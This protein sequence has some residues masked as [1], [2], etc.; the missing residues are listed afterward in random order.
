MSA[1]KYENLSWTETK[2]SLEDRWLI[3]PIGAIE[4]HGPHLPLAVDALLA[5][6][7]SWD[8]AEQIDAVV[9]PTLTY[10]G[11]SLPNSGGGPSYPGTIHLQGNTLID[12]YYQIITRFVHLGAE[13]ILLLNAHWENEPFMI[14]AVEICREYGV[15]EQAQVLAL[16]WWSV[17]DATEME[18]IFGEFHGWHVEHAGQAETALMLHY[19]PELV[20]MDKAVDYHEVIPAGI[21]QHPTPRSWVGNQGV[22]SPTQHVVP[23]MGNQL[24]ILLKEKIS[25]LV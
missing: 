16:S 10:G 17:I 8:V 19:A 18:R 11:R 13:K 15:L 4:Q 24:A 5:E 20:C 21:Y 22:L 23:E 3:I 2:N 9:A 1:I 12:M 6:H 14:E 25:A 7:I